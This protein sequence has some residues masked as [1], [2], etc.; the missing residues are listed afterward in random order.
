MKGVKC[1]Q[2]SS[3]T[4]SACL[5]PIDYLGRMQV[6]YGKRHYIARYHNIFG[7]IGEIP[8]LGSSKRLNFYSLCWQNLLHKYYRALF[9]YGG[10]LAILVNQLS[11]AQERVILG[12]PAKLPYIEPLATV[13][14]NAVCS[15]PCKA[16]L[17]KCCILLAG[18]NR[19]RQDLTPRH[20]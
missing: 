18:S 1:W 11:N 14:E 12:A 4:K 10:S 9:F 8:I 15:S 3:L 2:G 16:K 7:G 6:I 13:Y 19:N 17:R 5:P 20:Q